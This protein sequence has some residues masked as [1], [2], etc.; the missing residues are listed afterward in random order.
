MAVW[1]WTTLMAAA[2]GPLC[3]CGHR[4]HDSGP[5][6]HDYPQRGPCRT[7]GCYCR[8][9][10]PQPPP[11]VESFMKGWRAYWTEAG[12]RGGR[13]RWSGW[14]A[15]GIVSTLLYELLRAGALALWAYGR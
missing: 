4:D 8:M 7:A 3:V 13:W 14:A 9:F 11:R 6:W 15:G 2:E 12:G 1:S 10:A 5:G